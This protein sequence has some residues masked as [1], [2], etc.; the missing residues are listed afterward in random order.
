M[1]NQNLNEIFGMW[2]KIELVKKNMKQR[3]LAKLVGI[4]EQ[5]MC[6]WI[7]GDR[8]PRADEMQKVLDYFN[9]HI[10]IVPNKKG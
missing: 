3:D 4:T 6:R 1:M 2:L 10:E 5:S 8:T 7:H 9:C